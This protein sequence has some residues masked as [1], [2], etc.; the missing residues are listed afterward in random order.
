MCAHTH[1]HKWFVHE[2]FINTDAIDSCPT[3]LIRLILVAFATNFY[4]PI[5]MNIA[6]RMLQC[7]FLCRRHFEFSDILDGLPSSR[8][9]CAQF[10]VCDSVNSIV[11]FSPSPALYLCVVF[12]S[13]CVPSPLNCLKSNWL[14]LPDFPSTHFSPG[15]T[16]ISEWV[17]IHNNDLSSI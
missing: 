5:E 4:Y 17:C 8:R 10:I 1:T 6:M 13:S 12:F 11:S 14:A 9:V 15:Y 16:G 2:R 3:I 7:F